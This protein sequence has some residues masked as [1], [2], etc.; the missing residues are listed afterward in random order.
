M[1]FYL[2]YVLKRIL[3][4]AVMMRNAY[5]L[6]EHRRRHGHPVQLDLEGH[7]ER[8]VAVVIAATP[9]STIAAVVHIHVQSDC[10]LLRYCSS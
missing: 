5:H 6:E 7:V 1:T 8:E 4:C 3:L 9:F 2:K 10:L